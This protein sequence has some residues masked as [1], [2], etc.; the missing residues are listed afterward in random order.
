MLDPLKIRA[1]ADASG[2]NDAQIA[3]AAK[4]TH[5]MFSVLAN[6]EIVKDPALSTVERLAGALGCTILDL[7]TPGPPED[8][9][10]RIGM[11]RKR[12]YVR[13]ASKE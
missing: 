2:L 7:V 13:R 1:R 6:P 5:S 12:S 9:R 8:R 11:V 3:K 10:T 4:L